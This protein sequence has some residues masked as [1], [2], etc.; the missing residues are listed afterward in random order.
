MCLGEY[1]WGDLNELKKILQS[2]ACISDLVSTSVT[3]LSLIVLIH[4]GIKDA[5][6]LQTTGS[7]ELKKLNQLAVKNLDK[8]LPAT[9]MVNLST[10][11][12][13]ANE[14]LGQHE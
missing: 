11:L 1:E 5:C 2:F 3:S 7:D 6:A 9:Y 14:V 8:R 10:V 4:A 13:A 12:D